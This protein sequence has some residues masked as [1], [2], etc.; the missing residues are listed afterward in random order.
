MDDH[1]VSILLQENRSQ[2]DQ[3]QLFELLY[4]TAPVG[5]CFLDTDLRF[6][7][8]NER[9]AQINGRPVD[10][11]IG[12]PVGEVIP[13][14]KDEVEAAYRQ[15]LDT[16][17]PLLDIEIVGVTPAAPDEQRIWTVNYYPVFSQDN[18]L[19]GVST[20]VLDV[21]DL[22]QA[23][24]SKSAAEGELRQQKIQK[25]ESLERLSAG[26]AHHFDHLLTQIL[27]NAETAMLEL[28]ATSPAREMVRNIAIAGQGV[29][30]LTKQL[31]DY[32]GRP[33][34]VKRAVF[35]DKVLAGMNP[36]LC[37]EVSDRTCLLFDLEPAM[38]AANTDQIQHVLFNL[39]INA[40]QA[41]EQSG[42]TVSIRTGVRPV[43]EQ[44]R[45]Q[46]PGVFKN[47]QHLAFVQVADNGPGMDEQT[48]SKIFDPFFST[49][50]AG[51]GLG[52]AVTQGIVR[53]HGG[54]IDV[55]S[56]PGTGT[57]VTVCFAQVY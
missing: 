2:R 51:R 52:L 56:V 37:T 1:N 8:I 32:S 36:R 26:V 12:M 16:G 54:T 34:I 3:L 44:D 27:N 53:D 23:Q 50:S 38:V 25:L 14:L 10:E 31:L 39:I 22:R 7:R 46:S 20:M 40:S 4:R 49:Q 11:H 48:L 19:L 24:A 13:Q 57:T 43:T 18:T 5:L 15:V 9:L 29:A 6:V 47:V 17:K 33:S 55:K 28:P 41:I 30:D 45:E 21:T 42:D 35:L